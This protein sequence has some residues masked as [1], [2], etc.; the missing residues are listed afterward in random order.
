DGA[1]GEI[2]VG[3]AC[4]AEGYEGQAELTRQRF[5]A[6]PFGRLYR[7]GDLGRRLPGGDIICLDRVDTQGKVRGFRVQPSEVELAIRDRA[8]PH[9]VIREVAG[10]ARRRDAEMFLAA[11]L[12]GD[13]AKA[14]LD[15]VRRRLRASLPEPLVPARFAWLPRLPLTPSG[16]RDDS[17]LREIPL[18]PAT[19]AVE[20]TPPR[21][22]YERRLAE[23]PS[24]L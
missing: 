18:T 24:C 17:R 16:K 1:R 19:G 11:S 4:L 23:R 20:R 5:V 8:A 7:T 10:G 6:H 13:E 12:V 2:Y 15:D 14:D 21:D 22:G 9:P 3:G